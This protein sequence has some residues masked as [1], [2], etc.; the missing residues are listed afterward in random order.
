MAG[1]LSRPHWTG[2]SAVTLQG[3]KKDSI[4]SEFAKIILSNPQIHDQVF[5]TL[6]SLSEDGCEDDRSCVE[7]CINDILT[8]YK[9]TKIVYLVDPRDREILHP[10]YKLRLPDVTR[11]EIHGGKTNRPRPKEIDTEV[12][13][14]CE[15]TQ[16]RHLTILTVCVVIGICYRGLSPRVGHSDQAEK[17]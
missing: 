13:A 17:R 8:D 1:S 12:C 16:S 11:S 14:G 3:H 15:A 2:W 5:R 6:I 10:E 4:V 9:R 7:E